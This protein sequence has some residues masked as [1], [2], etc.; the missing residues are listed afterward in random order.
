[1]SDTREALEQM[2]AA[3][4]AETLGAERLGAETNFFALGGTSLQVARVILQLQEKLR[5]EIPVRSLLDNLTIAGLA[6]EIEALQRTGGARAA[7]V[8]G[9]ALERTG[10]ELRAPTSHAQ[11]AL[12]LIDQIQGA[13]AIY[14]IPAAVEVEGALDVAVLERA[15]AHLVERHEML[16][17]TF[18]AAGG[19]PEQVVH[20][21]IALPLSRIDLRV[22][23]EEERQIRAIDHVVEAA[24]ALFDLAAGP[25]FRVDVLQLTDEWH[26]LFFNMHH[27]I[28]DGRSV[29]VFIAELLEAYAALASGRRP[30]LPP[31]AV[32]YADFAAWQQASVDE[33][34][35]DEQVRYWKERL[36]EPLAALELPTD[37]VRPPAP[38][39]RGATESVVLP[40]P[41]VRALRD[42]A[43]RNGATLFMTVLSALGI[44]LHR[45]SGQADVVVGTPSAN[46]EHPELERM[47]GYFVNTLALR[48]DLSGEPTFLD[49]LASV[50]EVALGAYAHQ[51]VPF[52]RVV[53]E[54]GVDRGAQQPIFQV[55]LAFQEETPPLSLPGLR[56]AQ[57]DLD[58]DTAKF[59]LTLLVTEIDSA[60]RLSLEYSTDL[61]VAATARRMLDHLQVVL[62][63]VVETPGAL[64]SELGMLTAAEREQIAA[65][66]SAGGERYPTDRTLHGLFSE[67][68]ERTPDAVA[69]EDGATTLTYRELDRRANRVALELR[70]RGVRPEQFVGL[71]FERSS[72]LVTAI[73]GV[74]KAGAAYVPMDPTA[75][76]ERFAFMVRDTAMPLVVAGASVRHRLPVEGVPVVCLD[77]ESFDAGEDGAS[78]L[79]PDGAGD[80]SRLAYLMYTSGSTGVP[81]GVQVTHGQVTPV[82]L[83][84][85]DA[86]G[87]GPTDRVLQYLSY[88]FDWS[89]YEI[90]VALTSGA[91]LVVVPVEAWLDPAVA[92]ALVNERSVT[93]L[94]ITPTQMQGLV[95][96]GTPMPSVRAL[97][98]GAEKLPFDLAARSRALVAGDCRLYNM[99]GPTECA[100]I[101]ATATV[102]DAPAEHGMRLASV[103]IGP[104]AANTTCSVEDAYGNPQPVGVPGE[105]VLGGGS[106]ARGYLNRP[107][108]TAERFR[109]DPAA[110]G[111]RVYRTGDLARWLPDGQIEFLGRLDHQVKFR[112]VRVELGEIE[113][114]LEQHGAISDAVVTVDVT[115]EGDQRLVAYVVPA[116]G[117][118]VDEGEVR[119]FLGGKLPLYMLPSEIVRLDALPHTPNGKVDRQALP[120]PVRAAAAQ[121]AVQA[122][123]TALEETVARAWGEALGFEVTDVNTSFFNLGGSSLQVVGVI[124]ALRETLGL[125]IPLR[126]LFDAPTIADLTAHVELLQWTVESQRAPV[127]TSGD[128]EEGEL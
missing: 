104:P 91:R 122:P 121:V 105:L 8:I 12:W 7:A 75:P 125:E 35:I 87:L 58:T 84:G 118:D 96:V 99:Y 13:S 83:W 115:P 49:L 71:C 48:L 60:L 45:Y 62:E 37:L 25:L 116:G 124:S 117:A 44:L 95:A 52:E 119:V 63:G 5:L 92:V 111:G 54:V 11:R 6:R 72:A 82:V 73:L 26:V 38:S 68:V 15:L 66:S 51:D 43:R 108:L 21:R 102:T 114:S 90:F 106:V 101:S 110:P 77:E 59:D 10:G 81:K 47:L 42:L 61:F 97:V 86:I 88:F 98:L 74:L 36:R 126:A 100:I 40:R 85:H 28:T 67:Q 20:P 80:A 17:T 30:A 41:A 34:A 109:P 103:P 127:D 33:P 112:G 3:T 55:M 31:F 113:R 14:N 32:S 120:R 56:I 2:I 65:W 79:A 22:L 1:M 57:L 39:G 18:A 46:R 64:V 69:V 16:R 89:V 50:R 93:A 107:D 128:R 70:G 78:D 29:A 24:R 94:H 27:I 76:A 4:W 23:P 123:R 9:P 53:N 19:V